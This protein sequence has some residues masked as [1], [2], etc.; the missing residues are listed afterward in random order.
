MVLSEIY[1]R[2]F[3]KEALPF[4]IPSDNPKLVYELNPQYPGINSHGMRNEEFSIGELKGKYLIA[5]IGDSHTYSLVPL[6]EQAFP[7]K[8]QEYINNA[9]GKNNVRVINFGVG[10]YNTAQE[11]EVLKYKVL[12]FNPDLV[13]L[14]Y[15]INDTH[16][17]NYIQPENKAINSLIHKSRLLVRIWKRILYSSQFHWLYEYVGRVFPDALL[18]QEGLVGTLIINTA[19]EIQTHRGH[20]ARTPNKVPSRYH[21]MLGIQNF[22]KNIKE[23]AQICKGNN[24]KYVATGFIDGEVYDV[25][26]RNGFNIISF[27]EIFRNEDM[28]HYGY[29]P[30]KTSSHFNAEGCKLIGIS[31][32]N[33]ILDKIGIVVLS[34]GDSNSCVP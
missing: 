28:N 29:D 30:E 2:V 23:F 14:Q 12:K 16:V 25:F 5:V 21:Y 22:N 11:L 15:C 26:L 4:V 10:G 24:I 8:L 6:R 13:I 1:I 3:E 19:E 34:E 27:Y 33:F 9:V 31:L 20:P 18:Y 32:S 17:C 7:Q